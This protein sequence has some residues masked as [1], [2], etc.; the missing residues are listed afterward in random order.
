M[1]NIYCKPQ[2]KKGVFMSINKVFLLGKLQKDPDFKHTGKTPV[3]RYKL[4]TKLDYTTKSGE[5][6][7][8]KEWHNIK[9]FGKQAENDSRFLKE[10]SQVYIEGTIKTESW[11]DKKTGKKVYMTFIN[12]IDTKYIG[13][14]GVKAEDY[15]N[16]KSIDYSI[17][18][19][20]EPMKKAIGDNK[21]VSVEDLF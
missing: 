8:I 20:G 21:R 4:E 15:E 13:Q 2:K 17:L 7:E 6:K 10:N 5:K 16:R 1:I 19:D 9:S 14:D 18:K 3:C 11:D 12:P